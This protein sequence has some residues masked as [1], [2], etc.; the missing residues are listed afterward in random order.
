MKPKFNLQ[1]LGADN[2][3]KTT[4]TEAI[5]LYTKLKGRQINLGCDLGM[6]PEGRVLEKR[7]EDLGL[8]PKA[9]EVLPGSNGPLRMNWCIYEETGICIIN[10]YSTQIVKFD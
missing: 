9:Q 2:H 8:Y 10:D 5:L 4:L 3:G 6:T 7:F 1:I